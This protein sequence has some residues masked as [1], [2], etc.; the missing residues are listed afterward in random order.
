MRCRAGLADV[1]LH[2]LRHSFASTL[3]NAGVSLYEVQH[4]LGHAKS[5]TTQRYAHLA[6]SKLQET[7]QVVDRV[8]A[9][10]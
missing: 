1:R 2:D 7:V 10:D 8:Y 3:V 6:K 9:R 4:L 5:T